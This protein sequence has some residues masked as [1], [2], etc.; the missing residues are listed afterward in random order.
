[1]STAPVPVK[2][3]SS[4]LRLLL[5]ALAAVALAVGFAGC[6]GGSSKNAMTLLRRGFST[7]IHSA[8][9]TIDLGAEVQGLPTLSKPIQIKL[10][11]P[12]QSNGPKKLPSLNWTLNFSGGG[13]TFSAGVISTGD[14]AFVNFQG[15]NYEVGRQ[16]IAKYNQTL[17]QRGPS[18]KS[19]FKQF[20]VDPLSWVKGASDQGDAT[21]AGVTT[22]HVSAG[23]DVGKFFGDLNKILAKARGGVS[24]GT[25]QQ[26][27]KQQIDQVAKVL[28][29]PKFDVY[30][31]K[32]DGTLRRVS[33]SFGIDVPKSAQTSSGGVK[34]ANVTLSVEFAAV[35]E[36]Q[37][38]QAPANVRPIS[39]L[40]KQLGGLGGIG[41]ALGGALGGAGGGTGGGAGSTGGT[42]GG[43]SSP[44]SQQYKLYAACLNKAKPSDV[45]AIQRCAGLLK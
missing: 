38:I 12:Y 2:S 15:T 8:N 32:G 7:P 5:L 45:A 36:P 43:G 4:L 18:A 16:V 10:S 6:G 30:V 39:E 31:A 20:G 24:G 42:G 37:H 9:V 33:V 3:R 44:S 27:T 14:N 29:D 23:L 19:G 28:K 1:M 17:A 25:A 11:G 21:V 35:G 34:S 40:T 41:S 22:T 13:Q 26:L